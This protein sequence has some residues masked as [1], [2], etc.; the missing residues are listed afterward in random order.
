MPDW[1]FTLFT[2]ALWA[3]FPLMALCLV[4]GPAIFAS[5]YDRNDWKALGRIALVL[6]WYFT[7]MVCLGVWMNGH[8]RH[9]GVPPLLTPFQFAPAYWEFLRAAGFR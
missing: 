8:G 5:R 4:Y 9:V 7:A 2:R 6:V 3:L 1:Q